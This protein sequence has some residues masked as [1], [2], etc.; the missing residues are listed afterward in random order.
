MCDHHLLPVAN[1]SAGVVLGRTLTSM[2]EVAEVFNSQFPDEEITSSEEGACAAC[3]DPERWAEVEP[4]L[5]ELAKELHATHTA[6]RTATITTH[7][8]LN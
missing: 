7:Q 3:D 2:D 6:T 5:T 1:A 8:S 4:Q